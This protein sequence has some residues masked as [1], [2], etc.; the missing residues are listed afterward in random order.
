[1]KALI[2]AAF[3]RSRTVLLCLVFLL[4]S[5]II[6]YIT[7]PKESTPDIT[8][9][10]I[11]VSLGHEGISPQDAER[12]LVKAMEK[13]LQGLTG[14]KEMRSTSSEGHA[15]IILE[16]DAGFDSEVALTDVREKVDRAK[17]KLPEATDE[18]VV[19]E[20]NLALFPILTI[21]LSGPVPERALLEVAKNL[22]DRLEGLPEVFEA[23]IAGERQEVLE[24]IVD[25][26]VMETYGF[27]FESLFSLIQRNNLLVAAGAIDTGAGRMV[28]KVPGV[29]ENLEDIMSLPVKVDGDTVVTF[30]DVGSIRRTYKDPQGFARLDGQPTLALEISKRIG[31]N[32][33]KTVEAVR[34]TVANERKRWPPNIKVN[35]LQD[36]SKQTRTMLT[37]LQNNVLTGVILVMIVVMA[38]LGVRSA[39]LVGLAIPG[40]FLVGILV[41][42]SMGYTMNVIVLFSL[43]LVVGML[44][45]GAIIVAEQADRNIDNG[46][47]KHQAYA[48]AAK[49][50]AWPV[51][52][53]TATTLAVFFPLLFWP[54]M[55]GQFMRYMPTTV[56]IC[57]IA[58]LF[59]ALIFIPV[60]GSLI[61]K[62]PSER[63]RD[64][65]NQMPSR[66][67]TTYLDTLGVLLKSPAKTLLAT[68]LFTAV[69]YVGY[70]KFGN[71]TEFFPGIEPE[72]TMLQVHARG[73][74]S[75]YEK[76]RII[77]GIEQ[78]LIGMPELRSVY[79]RT[80][81]TTEGSELAEDVIGT[82]QM[83]LTDWNKR[84]K[85][86]VLVEEM[87]EKLADVAGVQLQFRELE[88]GPESGKP[89][90]IQISS[91]VPQKLDSAALYLVD[92]MKKTGGF[93]DIEDN[94]PLPGIEWIL[95]VDREQAAR[96][97]ADI[98]LVGNA[99]Q[100][101]TSGF[102][103]ADY[104]P[105]DAID[106]VD[107][108][109]RFPAE[110]RNLTQLGELRVPTNKGLIP[111]ANFVTVKPAPK[112]GNLTRVDGHRV[113]TIQADMQEGFLLDTQ[114]KELQNRLAQGQ[115]DP[116]INIVFKGEAAE[117]KE[118][119]IFLMTAF[120]TA[121]FLMVLILVTQFNSFYQALLILSA[122]VFSTA[123]VLIGLLISGQTFG[124]VMCGIGIIALSGI[125]V[126]NNI[127][128][129]DTYNTF[130]AQ[131]E[132][133]VTAA[134][135]SGGLRMRPV[136]LTAV[137][138]I[139][140]LMPMVLSLN[141][142]LLT[143]EITHGAP[144]TQ[145]WTQLASAIAG[146]LA[147]TTLLTL[148]LT[149]CL[150]VLGARTSAK[151]K[152]RKHRRQRA[153]L[154]EAPGPY[155]L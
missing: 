48:S 74:L 121:I 153:L 94:R 79:T 154:G 117:Q 113:V 22:Q 143:R 80:L 141:I 42:N 34:E 150:L 41:I 126:N 103:L 33:I 111:I 146:G 92:Q 116:D 32:L 149:P 142:N 118:T 85:A 124:L 144:S 63:K 28:L 132:S 130:R 71:G 30:G 125:V 72:V 95:D 37:D 1:M 145:W 11:Y 139:L 115:Q 21:S 55:I 73:D 60:F 110:E 102:K 39:M 54:G 24:I 5:G 136:L 25:P 26:T 6:S 78:K 123:G 97:G 100:M 46:M 14:L 114:L 147:F 27:S 17:N 83:E 109:V 140:G 7:I 62:K 76:D 68:M 155:P 59:M 70:A 23:E 12:L 8:I 65:K 49:R 47:P 19:T 77:Q 16:F 119:G 105:D 93:I 57:L 3:L 98:S 38:A 45:D 66:L 104:R 127:V 138:T 2:D 133:A 31:A 151:R 61:G 108:R 134:L 120:A 107:I 75:I 128:L 88:S 4:I 131:G 91:S 56:I 82:L 10:I 101:I 87:R 35:F 53:S 69:V 89:V 9:P 36:Q 122:V 40:S 96:Y 20:I 13:E 67:L 148:F 135:K 106:E 44:V 15:S 99:I 81:D 64:T 129:I 137:T 152:I 90:N 58:S 43:I 51:T 18:P 112:T 84:R 86:S 52:A 29:I 50:M